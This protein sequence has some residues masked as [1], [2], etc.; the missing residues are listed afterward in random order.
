MLLLRLLLL[1]LRLLLLLLLFL[2]FLLL[3]LWLLRLLRLRLLLMLLPLLPLL[4]KRL[5]QLAGGENP[6]H[7]PAGEPSSAAAATVPRHLNGAA[8]H[9]GSP[10]CKYLVSMMYGR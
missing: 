3:L 10:G 6:L 4:D 5:L 8:V 2:L 9:P 7:L 1:L